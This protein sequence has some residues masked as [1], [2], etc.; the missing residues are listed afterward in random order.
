MLDEPSCPCWYLAGSF[1]AMGDAC[2]QTSLTAGVGGQ[3][4]TKKHTTG[5]L[6]CH[7]SFRLFIRL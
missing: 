4:S 1:G 3:E 7:N 2:D 5:I 6:V